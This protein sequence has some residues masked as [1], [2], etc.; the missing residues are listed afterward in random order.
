MIGQ[1]EF[2]ITPQCSQCIYINISTQP[3]SAMILFLAKSDKIFQDPIMVEQLHCFQPGF[4][5]LN[6]ENSDHIYFIKE[7]KNLFLLHC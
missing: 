4:D 6:V 5:F 7:I 2:I 3:T 1:I